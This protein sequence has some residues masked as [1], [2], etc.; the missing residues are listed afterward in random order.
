MYTSINEWKQN[1]TKKGFIK[2]GKL[3]EDFD[4]NVE[5]A[6][7]LPAEEDGV[8][9]I[10][11]NGIVSFETFKDAVLTEYENSCNLDTDTEENDDSDDDESVEESNSDEDGEDDEG[12][13]TCQMLD[14]EQLKIA[15]DA[16]LTLTTDNGSE[17]EDEEDSEEDSEEEIEDIEEGIGSFLRGGSKE[18]IEEKRKTITN[19]LE[20]I[21]NKYK[22]KEIVFKEYG[23]NKNVAYN[24][25]NVL[26]IINKNNF[27]GKIQVVD[28]KDKVFLIYR[29]GKKGVNKIANATTPDALK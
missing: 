19:Q 14:E 4:G 20:E 13:A 18:E 16:F 17:T 21:E 28:K 5:D 8:E 26:K 12:R 3:A 11:D 7:F 25:E 9:E 2:E 1:L 24:K 27:L 10:E 29:E 6:D 22:D 15:Y 23:D